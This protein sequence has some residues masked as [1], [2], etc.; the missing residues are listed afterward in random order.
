M[1]VSADIRARC[2][3]IMARQHGLITRTQALST[4]LSRRQLDG[5]LASGEWRKLMP[6]V[7][8]PAELFAT[9]HQRVIAAC[10]WAGESAAASHGTAAHLLGF[11]GFPREGIEICTPRRLVSAGVVVH[12][13]S[14]APHHVVHVDRIPVTSVPKTLVDVA[15]KC[16]LER[17]E[18]AV[19][20][21][22]VRGL[23]TK[24]R[25]Q[26]ELDG[27]LR[28]VPGSAPLRRVVESYI[29]APIESP[30]ERKFLRLL[31]AA[32]LPE[33]EVQYRIYDG[34]RLL[35]RV[36]FAYPELWLAME[37]DGFRW[38]GGRTGWAHDLS[39]GNALTNRR[40]RLLHI[41]KEHMDGSGAAAVALV[42][43][44]RAV[45]AL[46]T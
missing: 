45:R 20:N 21:V 23:T 13:R 34:D 12:Q 26:T 39:R 4:G 16:S 35:A 27:H 38:H 36:D 32:G 9:W 18:I 31:R 29:H 42:T 22:L 44:A 46:R 28:A 41:T 10:L 6:T 3:A 25:L 8:A 1:G 30:L 43:E 40:W 24:D 5:R 14:L 33:P 37:V 17:L 11:P 15:A 2:A 19:D 7:Y